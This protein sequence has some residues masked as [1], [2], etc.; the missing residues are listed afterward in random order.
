MTVMISSTAQGFFAWRIVKLTKQ[1]WLGWLIAS[2]IMLQFAA[3]LAGSI[4]GFILNEFERFHQLKVPVIVWLVSSVVTDTVIT[5][6]LIWYLHTHRTGYSKTDDRIS[7][8]VRNTMQTGLAVTVW[9]TADL[10]L[11]LVMPY[12]SMHLFFQLPLCKLYTA[13]LLSTLNARNAIRESSTLGDYSETVR[14]WRAGNVS[15]DQSYAFSS[16]ESH[17]LEGAKPNANRRDDEHESDK[18]QVGGSVSSNDIE[19][20]IQPPNLS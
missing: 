18:L 4:G 20:C 17:R 19:L 5:S 6:I 11:F 1:V 16:P 9:A 14:A 7:R 12:N 13:S 3:G 15:K 2:T 10:V 8:I